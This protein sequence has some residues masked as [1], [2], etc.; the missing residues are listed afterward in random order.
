[1]ITFQLED[2]AAEAMVSVLNAV[3]PTADFVQEIK[4]QYEA[5]KPVVEE[6]PAAAVAAFMDGVPHE[7]F[8]EEAVAEETP[9]DEPVIKA[10]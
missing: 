4:A 10:E 7:Q 9:V 2:K 5:A 8:D 6:A 3:H 1:M